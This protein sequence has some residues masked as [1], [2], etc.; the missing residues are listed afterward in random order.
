MKLTAWATGQGVG[1]ADVV[2]EVDALRAVIC[3]KRAP[4]FAEGRDG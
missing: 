1:V 3:A 2:T 4:R